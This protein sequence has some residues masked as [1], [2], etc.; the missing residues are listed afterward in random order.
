MTPEEFIS[1]LPD[2]DRRV[3]MRIALAE[4][5][6]LEQTYRR[7]SDHPADV[8]ALE[9]ADDIL[10]GIALAMTD[11]TVSVKIARVNYGYAPVFVQIV[12]AGD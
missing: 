11:P 9:C 12:R 6:Y 10:R 7:D 3:T 5:R 8:A 2:G 1:Q 4:A